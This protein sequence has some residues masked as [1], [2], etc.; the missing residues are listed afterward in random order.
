[1]I[2]LADLNDPVKTIN[3][4]LDKTLKKDFQIFKE[5]DKRN[6]KLMSDYVN[7][8]EVDTEDNVKNT[9]NNLILAQTTLIGITKNLDVAF[10]GVEQEYMKL[11]D[12]T[13]TASIDLEIHNAN[14]DIGTDK[15]NG[16]NVINYDE[17]EV[18]NNAFKT[19]H[20]GGKSDLVRLEEMKLKTLLEYTKVIYGAFS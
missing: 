13:L 19:S 2:V 9:P 7:G 20:R 15:S 10:K 3:D 8:L 17:E 18:K 1:M 4:L 5:S 6:N 14:T 16:T 11:M 12:D